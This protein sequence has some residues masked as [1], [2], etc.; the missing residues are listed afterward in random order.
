MPVCPPF[1]PGW[2]W[3]PSGVG[4]E[5]LG[6]TQLRMADDWVME[7]EKQFAASQSAPQPAFAGGSNAM[8]L[9]GGGEFAYVSPAS[10]CPRPRAP[11]AGNL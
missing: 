6:I 4:G 2:R 8:P 7:A 5:Q 11:L 3:E 9:G 10:P 1:P